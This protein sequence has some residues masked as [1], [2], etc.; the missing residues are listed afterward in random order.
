MSP[1]LSPESSI[2][3][4]SSSSSHSPSPR[5]RCALTN[6]RSSYQLFQLRL[7]I[8]K[9]IISRHWTLMTQ[10]PPVLQP[11]IVVL[12][13][14]WVGQDSVSLSRHY[15]LLGHLLLLLSLGGPAR[16]R[17]QLPRQLPERGLDLA[18][19]GALLNR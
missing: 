10:H 19:T 16:V 17:M 9:T 15:K 5:R 11:A 14:D 2:C 13:K 1:P 7:P 4:S 6:R 3:L 12:S 8:P 18:G